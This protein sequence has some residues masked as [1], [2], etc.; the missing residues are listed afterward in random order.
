MIDTAGNVSVLCVVGYVLGVT[1]L[2]DVVY[3]VC[4][5]SSTIT[6]F[7]ATTRQPLTNINVKDLSSP[8]LL[9]TSDAADE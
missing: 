8:C 1:Q 6:R 4:A 2:D 9:Y 3:M 7:N 5:G